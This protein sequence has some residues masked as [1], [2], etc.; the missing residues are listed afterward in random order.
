M[1]K[2]I[3]AIINFML[4]IISFKAFAETGNDT[5]TSLIIDWLKHKQHSYWGTWCEKYV[6]VP[7]RNVNNSKVFYD[8]DNETDNESVNSQL[9]TLSIAN[10]LLKSKMSLV[11]QL[12]TQNDEILN[13][14]L[15]WIETQ[16]FKNTEYISRQ[17]E[18][19]ASNGRNCDLLLEKLLSRRNIDGGWG[20]DN[21]Y[22]SNT[23]DT[24]WALK[25]LFK[26][27]YRNDNLIKNALSNLLYCSYIDTKNIRESISS[28]KGTFNVKNSN[29]G[30]YSVSGKVAKSLSFDGNQFIN[31]GNV[32]N[33]TSN[34]SISTWLYLDD[35]ST[36]MPVNRNIVSKYCNSSYRWRVE[37][38]GNFMFFISGYDPVTGANKLKDYYPTPPYNLPRK[39]WVHA[40]VTVNFNTTPRQLKYYV[41]GSQIGQPISVDQTDI[42]P[43]TSAPLLI[44]AYN[45]EGTE[46]WKGMIDDL[47]IY[48]YCLTQDEVSYIYN[49]GNSFSG[50][51][52][53]VY[54]PMDDNSDNPD[55]LNN[56]GRINA[57]Y[58]NEGQ[59]SLNTSDY[60]TQG[61]ILRALRFN[62]EGN[63][64]QFINCGNVGNITS[65]ISI[66][67]WLYL[68][69]DS[70]TMSVNRNIV[71]KYC[72]S[73]YRW[74]VEQN[75]NLMFFICGYDPATGAND[76]KGYYP[77][78]SYNL[79]RKQ[80]VHAVVTVNFNTTPR[81]LKYYINGSQI[82][83][84]ISVDLTDI[85][86]TTNS[87]LLIGAYNTIGVEPWKG[88]ID[89]FKIYNYCLTQDEVSY[90]Y[91]SGNSFSGEQPVVYYPM[92]DNIVFRWSSFH[93]Y[94]PY[95]IN[96]VNSIS[97][98]EDSS[99]VYA[100]I[101]GFLEEHKS[102][103][104]NF[105][106]MSYPLNTPSPYSSN[107]ILSIDVIINNIRSTLLNKLAENNLETPVRNLQETAIIASALKKF[108]TA[109]NTTLEYS[110]NKL[111]RLIVVSESP[112]KGSF[113]GDPYLTGLILDCIAQSQE[114]QITINTLTVANNIA[115]AEIS[116]ISWKTAKFY[117]K[118]TNNDKYIIYDNQTNKTGSSVVT[119]CKIPY[120]LKDGDKIAICINSVIWKEVNFIKTGIADIAIYNKDIEIY[121]NDGITPVPNNI[122][123]KSSQ[124]QYFKI[125][126]KIH[127]LSDINIKNIKVYLNN[128]LD[129]DGIVL[130]P[131][132]KANYIYR[133]KV[134]SGTTGNANISTRVEA[135]GDPD[136]DNNISQSSLY[137]LDPE[138]D[139]INQSL[140]PPANLNFYILKDNYIMLYWDT[141]IDPNVIG[142]QTTIYEGGNNNFLPATLQTSIKYKLTTVPKTFHVY[143]IDKLS[144]RS[145]NFASLTI[146]SDILKNKYNKSPHVSISE[147]FSNK[148]ICTVKETA[149][150]S[151]ESFAVFGTVKD[152]L[153]DEYKVELINSS[154]TAFY[155][156][157]YDNDTPIC[158]GLLA[159]YSLDNANIST[160]SYTLRVT[161]YN[162]AGNTPTTVSIPVKISKW[163]K[164][165]VTK[166][167][168]C[169]SPSWNTDASALIFSARRNSADAVSDDYLVKRLWK[170][171]RADNTFSI[172]TNNFTNDIEPVWINTNDVL[173]AS[174]RTG[175]R[176][177]VMNSNNIQ[178]VF[179]VVFDID[180][181]YLT[182]NPNVSL[183]DSVGKQI[184][185][186][187][188]FYNPDCIIIDNKK[189]VIA[190]DELGEL[191][192][193]ATDNNNNSIYG[194]ITLNLTE[195][196]GKNFIL[197]DKP[198]FGP[199]D[200]VTN[201]CKIFFEGYNF[202]ISENYTK[203]DFYINSDIFCLNI[204]LATINNLLTTYVLGN[205]II[206][207]NSAGLDGRYWDAHGPYI[208]QY[209]GVAKN[210]YFYFQSGYNT[211]R[212]AIYSNTVINGQDRPDN[213]LGETFVADVKTGCWVKCPLRSIVPLKSGMKYWLVKYIDTGYLF[214]PR[215]KS[216]GTANLFQI[217]IPSG[218]SH[219]FPAI[220]STYSG[221]LY[222]REYSIYLDY[223]KYPLESCYVS[224]S[225]KQITDTPN[226]CEFSPIWLD[227][228]LV[229]SLG[230]NLSFASDK[231]ING[232]NIHEWNIY[233]ATLN[234]E[235]FKLSSISP[236]TNT[237]IE[238]NDKY[239]EHLNFKNNRIAYDELSPVDDDNDT[240][241]NRI[242]YL[243]MN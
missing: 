48:N 169:S 142:Y 198:R 49:S 141:P 35:D 230:I 95:Y 103:L 114:P 155:P 209:D 97:P 175:S 8:S 180:E 186:Q 240:R 93:P 234:P 40:V 85:A 194:N 55:V 154:N 73:S 189:Y 191:V 19:L 63:T 104:S 3:L 24:I 130:I 128:V 31:C 182:N 224:N 222:S 215:Y 157:S 115:V 106:P 168:R 202:E 134:P 148:L 26:A 41:N 177:I 81:Q 242:W 27:G 75:G 119:S 56:V 233:L 38:N 89:D 121:D 151:Y 70:T 112:D 160:G 183:V 1:I 78:P 80:W 176:N 83:Q 156:E 127:N 72:N 2:K 65:N 59:A 30:E 86:P 74:R 67:T 213:K 199:I 84:P 195:A 184:Y 235:T 25:A 105:F 50:E 162:L 241:E 179:N 100:Y 13:K 4:I 227:G 79:P 43:T 166:G 69:D 193:V 145:S 125:K 190:S 132:E 62:G 221:G 138:N 150:D 149:N 113:S 96:S 87:P 82:G 123:L 172:F 111:K 45:T 163:Q 225:L 76:L 159:T 208:A 231:D 102:Y 152:D 161:A 36:T 210:I 108:S 6:V 32:G 187:K 135:D 18:I 124:D 20:E 229:S 33:V 181:H 88:M 164:K 99:I 39:Q 129:C 28:S 205:N 15:S 192:L 236:I 178:N 217:S 211:I 196:D 77:T 51:Q 46:P 12:Q 22:Q 11:G 53:V 232:D 21:G 5:T 120:I 52:P 243:D 143:S 158:N 91:N 29:Y 165:L 17:I 167:N 140:E 171:F 9:A 37:Q 54:Y 126:Q 170:W 98:R 57:T 116:T 237:L 139:G 136:N 44:G 90:I 228:T 239:I 61:K 16:E 216:G 206:E 64:K 47:K 144:K 214:Y 220:I 218:V 92:D 68:D 238:T 58:D 34:I 118:P 226:E 122:I 71:S 133:F 23:I 101:Y 201:T 60:S 203:D 94:S 173:Y 204:S 174:Y 137:I 117:I 188:S 185:Y 146:N 147:P 131:Y 10:S 110:I 7:D 207:Q 200:T 212:C 107:K 66:S 223:E 153:F 109:N 219:E 42:A 197:A 14:S